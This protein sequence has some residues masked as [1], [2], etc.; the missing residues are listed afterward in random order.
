MLSDLSAAL[1]HLGD[2]MDTETEIPG[3]RRFE[4]YVQTHWRSRCDSS[5]KVLSARACTRRPRHS[6]L[7]STHSKLGLTGGLQTPYNQIQ[8]N[9]FTSSVSPYG[10]DDDSSSLWCVSTLQCVMCMR[11]LGG[12]ALV[13]SAPCHAMPYHAVPPP[14]GPVPN[15]GHWSYGCSCAGRSP[16]VVTPAMTPDGMTTPRVLSIES[17]TDYPF[18]SLYTVCMLYCALSVG[19]ALVAK[20]TAADC[21]AC[22]IVLDSQSC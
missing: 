4:S 21:P 12:A 16:M 13:R 1:D 17:S 3:L 22:F 8:S 19:T 18:D 7:R 6:L 15:D 2:S 11:L 10:V 14:S 20:P 5:P 9:V